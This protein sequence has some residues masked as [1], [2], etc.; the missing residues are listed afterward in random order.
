[1]SIVIVDDDVNFCESLALDFSDDGHE[2]YFYTSVK[3]FLAATPICKY[4]VLDLRL[5]SETSTSFLAEIRALVGNKTKIII[6]TGFGSISTTVEAMR[7]GADDYLTKPIRYEV[8]KNKVIGIDLGENEEADGL[9]LDQA[10]REHIEFILN[11]CH[12]NITKAAKIL[13][14]HRQSLQRKLKKYSPVK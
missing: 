6:L 10:E 14:I 2:V 13:G 11:S 5:G 8:L 1:M 12:G 7:L 3:D 4:L 9:K